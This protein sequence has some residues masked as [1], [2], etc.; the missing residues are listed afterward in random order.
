[1]NEPKQPTFLVS[2]SSD[3]IIVQVV[4]KANYTNCN[5][6]REFIET[7]ID[8][9]NNHIIID[10]KDCT[11]MDSTF[12]GILA[13][14][15]L[16]LRSQA[17]AGILILCNLSEHNYQLVHNLGLH[18]L[19]TIAEDLMNIIEASDREKFSVLNNVEVSDARE[20]LKA[21]ENLVKADDRNKDQFQ[22]VITFLKTQ[23]ED[24]GT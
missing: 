7:T 12:L 24:K 19:L 5:T 22:D 4:G 1:M 15:A 18:D 16:G 6:F 2:A 8:A 13:G 11:G 20:I 21:H 23:T 9:A 14:T 10:L 3:P 17:P